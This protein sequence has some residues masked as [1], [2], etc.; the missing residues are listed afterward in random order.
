MNWNRLS[1]LF[2]ALILLSAHS[3]KE[4]K[5]QKKEIQTER[6]INEKLIEFN[7]NKLKAEDEI[8][9]DYVK[10][11]YPDLETTDTGLRY[12]IYDIEEGDLAKNE[13]VAVVS[14]RI[15]RLN[16]ELLYSTEESGPVHIRIGH[17]DVPSGLHEG[18]MYMSS[19]DSALFI[20]P[21]HRAYGFTGDQSSIPQNAFLI[22]HVELIDL[23]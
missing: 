15:E 20:M 8:I 5:Q 17:E 11:N 12:Y 9:D 1:T 21:S 2:V 14:Y 18:L 13:E 16:G 7:K 3:C 23:E 22:Y 10:E 6:E 4:E 19:G